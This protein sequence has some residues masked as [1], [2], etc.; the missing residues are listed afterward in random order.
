MCLK[1]KS[2]FINKRS[3]KKYQWTDSNRN[4]SVR[5]HQAVYIVGVILLLY[6]QRYCPGA[7]G[8]NTSYFRRLETAFLSIPVVFVS[9]PSNLA[10]RQ[11]LSIVAFSFPP[12]PIIILRKRNNKKKLRKN[13]TGWLERDHLT[14]R[15]DIWALSLRLGNIMTYHRPTTKLVQRAAHQEE[16]K[17]RREKEERK[18]NSP[19]PPLISLQI[20]PWLLY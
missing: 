5:W 6:L 4:I 2:S 14:F 8:Q 11:S 20:T 7:F 10:I 3:L 9:P 19:S 13:Q 16:K 17:K 18:K 1:I 12:A 15:A